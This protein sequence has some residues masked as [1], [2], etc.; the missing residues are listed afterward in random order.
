MKK[1]Y[2][3]VLV[4]ALLIYSGCDDTDN[5]SIQLV[6]NAGAS[7]TVKPLEDVTLDGTA[8][9]GPEGF[10]YS[11]TYIGD[12][13]EDE[14]NFQNTT[15]ATPTF[16]PPK[17]DIYYFTLTTRS[18]D[19][20]STDEV[21]IVASGG[22]EIGGTLSEDLTLV[23]IEPDA[24]VPDY[25][26]TSDLIVPAG[27]T[28]SVGEEH[29][30][31]Y[32]NEGFGIHVQNGAKFTNVLSSSS[33]SLEVHFTGS[34]TDGWKGIWIDNG[35][36]E[37]N[38][39]TIEYA[40][41]TSFD[42]MAEP[43]SLIMSGTETHLVS[44][45]N[46]EIN[47]SFSYS[48][49]V[50]DRI[51]GDSLFASNTL[52]YKHPMKAQISFVEHF[53]SS[54]PNLYPADHEYNIMVPSGANTKDDCKGY[55]FRFDYGN[56]LI[57]GDFYAGNDVSAAEATIYIKEGCG[58]VTEGG[59]SF[60]GPVGSTMTVD[61]HNNAQ[62]K[63]IAIIGE[64]KSLFVTRAI[65]K[66]GGYGILS[67]GDFTAEES[68]TLYGTAWLGE[69]QESTISDGGG[70]GYYNEDT[71]SNYVALSLR[72]ATF[73]NLSKGGIRTNVPSIARLFYT[74]EASWTFDLAPG[75]P[76]I[77]V[78]GDGRSELKWFD[79]GGDN[80]YLINARIQVDPVAGLTF[81]KGVHLKFRSGRSFIYNPTPNSNYAPVKFAGTEEQ[82][83]IF[84]GEEDSPGSWGGVYLGG[85]DGWFDVNH[86]IFRNAGEFILPGAT[87]I[88]N[89]I[90][91]YTGSWTNLIRFTNNTISGSSGHGIVVETATYDPNYEDSG[92]NNTF[93]DNA[94]GDVLIK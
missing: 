36:I 14:I 79:L 71:T 22:I 9:T 3:V 88:A 41:K 86:T 20:V 27:I 87:E 31:V 59:I 58:I 94:S 91:A 35:T 47:H 4:A 25:I 26:I 28:L 19:Q 73:S 1:L 46:N 11:W 43:A 50:T 57:D 40:G 51:R 17:G 48:V 32:A 67:A 29:V 34:A 92:K 30:L 13:P 65:I 23:N 72:D 56:F 38:D 81:D 5:E 66:N 82:P 24:D 83:V 85:G 49:L 53:N 45:T 61:G 44:V 75:V 80:F 60:R 10:T 12:V 55:G 37:L 52:S 42:G 64:Q 18:G 7:Q 33:E 63:G 74:L 62:W 90:S 68:A 69:I 54:Y 16:T 78:E 39:A 76:A 21:T 15:S 70:F 6:A 93:F 89:I 8:S 77:L 2:F 84:E